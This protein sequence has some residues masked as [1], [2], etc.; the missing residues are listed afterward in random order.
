MATSQHFTP[1]PQQP[2]IKI[3][4]AIFLTDILTRDTYVSQKW[5]NFIRYSFLNYGY[6]DGGFVHIFF[7][8]ATSLLAAAYFK[9]GPAAHFNTRPF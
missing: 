7:K 8:V 4:L 2:M 9:L 3:F 6:P 1:A 5:Y